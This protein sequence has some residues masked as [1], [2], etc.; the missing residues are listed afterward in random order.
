MDDLIKVGGGVTGTALSAAATAA[1]TDPVYQIISLI[2]TIVGL[3][4][5]I[6][7]TIVIPIIRWYLRAHRDGHITD[8]E[9]QDL[10][11]TLDRTAPPDS[12]D[13][14]PRR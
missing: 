5:T 9:L 7:T 3:L 2:T 10:S 6:A 1:Q 13:H 8:D 12:R 14:H 11:D 4:V